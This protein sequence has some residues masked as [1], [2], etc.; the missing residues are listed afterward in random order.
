ML[1]H[2]TMLGGISAYLVCLGLILC[3]NKDVIQSHWAAQNL[4]QLLDHKM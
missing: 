2:S 4:K 3:E 1:V